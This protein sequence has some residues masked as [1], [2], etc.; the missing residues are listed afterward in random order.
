MIRYIYKP[1]KDALMIC[2]PCSNAGKVVFDARL[3][4]RVLP[5]GVLPLAAKRVVRRKHIKLV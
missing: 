3:K 2:Y 4:K 1:G 5:P